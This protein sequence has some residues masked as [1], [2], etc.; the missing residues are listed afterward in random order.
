VRSS[1]ASPTVAVVISSYSAGRWE[2]LRAAASSSLGES[3]HELIVVIDHNDALLA[4]ARDALHGTRVLANE[5]APGLSGSR[6]TGVRHSTADVVAFLDDD[7]EVCGGWLSALTEPFARPEVL[8]VGGSVVPRWMQPPP[9]WLPAE[10]Y[11]VIGCSY[12]GLPADGR[13]MRNPIGANMAFR[14]DALMAVGGFNNR[15]GR[16]GA[17][18]LGCEETECAIRIGREHSDGAILHAPGA[19]VVHWVP[20]E[21]TTWA[22][23]RARCWSEGLSK[24]AVA[25]EVGVGRGLSSERSYVARVLPHGFRRALMDALRGDRAALARA[26]AIV[27]GLALTTAGYLRGRLALAGAAR[28]RRA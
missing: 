11:W 26:A 20:P 14:R 24:A 27:L 3:P 22:Y 1:D 25:A 19:R 9:A 13:P 17:V 4:R 23:F 5:E 18:P 8:G 21:R 10:F 6:N 16:I 28:S 2:M 12:R 7:A 15:I